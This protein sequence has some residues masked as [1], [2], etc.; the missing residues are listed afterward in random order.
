MTAILLARKSTATEGRSKSIEEQL[1]II[2]AD[3]EKFGFG[4][5]IEIAEPEGDKGHWW[6]DDHEGRNPQPYRSGLTKAV[7][8]IRSGEAQAIVVYKISRIVR[9]NGVHDAIAKLCREHGV[10]LISGGR[11]QELDTAKGLCDS[12]IDA[13]RAREWRDSISEDVL[14]DKDYKFQKLLFTKDPSCYGMRSKGRGT[15]AVEFVHE[16]L[17]VVRQVFDW[18]VGRGGPRLGTHQI[19]QRLMELGI[20]LSVG[21]RGHKA[22]DPSVVLSTQVTNLLQ[23]PQYAAMW[24]M[25]GKRIAGRRVRGEL[26]HFPRLLVPPRDGVGEPAPCVD[27]EIWWEAQRLLDSRPRA[28]AKA[29]GSE[30][31][32]AGLVVCGACGRNMHL[33]PKT[34]EGG[35]KTWR[36]HCSHRSKGR[37]R[38]CFGS[39]TASITMDELDDW[40]REYLAPM[41]AADLEELRRERESGPLARE[42]KELE[43]ALATAREAETIALRRALTLDEGQ[44]AALSR[45]LREEREGLERRLREARELL[46][47]GGSLAA[48]DPETLPTAAS[49][50]LKEALRRMVR[51]VALTAE[52]VVVLTAGGWLMAARYRERDL[53][54]YG[55]AEN[56][57]SVLPPELEDYQTCGEWFADPASFVAGRRWALGACGD[58]LS[59][60]ELL[61]EVEHGQVEAIVKV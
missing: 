54:V 45:S 32:L 24:E 31:I 53:T 58:R 59:A 17:G 36:W 37:T 43:A 19:A 8:L 52:G 57:R 6:F 28:G 22:K 35:A 38:T 40:A 4:K 30:R 20:P 13:A 42:A 56:R 46:G 10:R 48:Y 47:D 49:A 15:Q 51:W 33:Q 50:D 39:S 9:D 23:N 44:F 12:A 60:A 18:Y 5:V 14:R 27:P 1:E 41:V 25:G 3:T 11:D 2:R 55:T 16:E 21:A 29:A 7:D 34:L 26:K 61:P